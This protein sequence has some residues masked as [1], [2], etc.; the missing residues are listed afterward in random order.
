M[1]KYF[2]FQNGVKINCGE[3]ALG[4][5]GTELSYFGAKAPL[6]LASTAAQKLGVTSKVKSALKQASLKEAA[7]SEYAETHF[8]ENKVREIKAVYE[9][10]NCDS[11][12][13]VGGDATMEAAKCLRL[14]LTENC[15]ELVPLLGIRNSKPREIPLIA[16]PTENG[17]GKEAG[18][19][20]ETDENY[21]SSRSLV[22]NVVIIDEQSATAA[23]TRTVAACGVA[24]LTNAIEAYI[25]TEE[26]S[27]VEIYAEKAIRLLSKHLLKAVENSEDE[28]ACRA[29]ALAETLAGIAYAEA[30]YGQAH[31]LAS[32]IATISGEPIE[33]M[34]SITLVPALENATKFAEKRVKTLLLAIVGA[35]EYADTPK[36]E[37][38]QRTITEIAGLLEKLHEESD[39]PTKLSQTAITR[40]QFGKIAEAAAD[41]RAAIGAF[42]PTTREEFLAL[43]NAAY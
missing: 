25:N 9:R 41:T 33:E 6:L 23:P 2:E 15:E 29:T 22:P 20:L 43:L 8:D 17:T 11:I 4:T 28:E 16:I 12:I 14:F 13:A 26:E 31:A 32:G 5:I 19:Y 24:A 37:R 1:R 18:G 3:N 42:S 38:T 30:P 21:V 35:D 10:A 34:Y 40:E 27:P 36:E 39:I 7:F